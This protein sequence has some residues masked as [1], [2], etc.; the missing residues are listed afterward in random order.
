MRA[1]NGNVAGDEAPFVTSDY[2]KG[3]AVNRDH[4]ASG[5]SGFESRYP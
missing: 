1:Q 2:D 5:E 4:S 3:L